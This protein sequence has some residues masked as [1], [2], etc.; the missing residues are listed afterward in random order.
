MSL[1][2]VEPL[3]PESSETLPPARRRRRRRTIVPAGEHERA[4]LLA[5]L[6]ERAIPSFDFFLFSLLAGLVLA[7]ALLVDSP[8]LMFLAALLAPF[9]APVIGASLGAITGAG[10]YL[11]Q[12]LASLLIACVMIFLFGM[13]AGWAAMLLPAQPYLQAA[14]YSQFTWAGFTVLALG[15]GFSTYLMVR[16]PQQKPLVSSAAIAFSLYLPVGAAGFGAGSGQGALL[17]GGLVLFTVHLAWAILIGVLTLAGL[18]L[19]PL[20]GAG[21]VISGAF[22]FLGAASLAFALWT[23]SPL[24]SPIAG[25]IPS[26]TPPNEAP[27]QDSTAAGVSTLTA[28]ITPTQPT[29]TPSATPEPPTPTFTPTRTLIPSRTPTLTLSPAPTPV[30]AK[31][32]AREGNGVLVRAEPNFSSAVVTSLLNNTLVEL[33]PEEVIDGNVRW[34]QIR[35]VDD[36]IGWVVSSLLTTA[37]PSPNQ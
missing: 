26:P 18:G 28:T 1:P 36:K 4:G 14:A 2:T 33:L 19:R 3:P 6:S 31:I 11:L 34:V 21:I 35:T 30:W 8:A 17:A 7:A 32:T 13:L 37:T 29:S 16:S 10:R 25:L 20:T 5:E 15:T 22:A 9:M 12:S 27:T 23:A 24:P